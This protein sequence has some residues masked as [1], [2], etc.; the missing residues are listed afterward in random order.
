MVEITEDEY[1][2]WY[3]PHA[4]VEALTAVGFDPLNVYQSILYRA[5]DE[6]GLRAVADK[7]TVSPQGG[8]VN[9]YRFYILLPRMWAI[10]S[11]QPSFWDSG[12]V[13]FNKRHD[14]RGPDIIYSCIGIRF[15]PAG[16]ARLAAQR[17]RPTQDVRTAEPASYNPRPFGTL[18]AIA[19]ELRPYMTSHSIHATRENIPEYVL[20]AASKT[21]TAAE[22]DVWYAAQASE[23]QSWGGL[24]LRQ[25]CVEDHDGRRVLKKATDHI[26]KDRKTGRKP[27]SKNV[28]R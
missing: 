3:S 11:I 5:L 27:G 7:L 22:F 14:P 10:T 24:K 28:P 2:R 19:P 17:S 1:G 20:P 9:S 23:I 16:V 25:K 12:D 13:Q 18:E 6:D 4:A 8:T 26:T 15:D 21:I